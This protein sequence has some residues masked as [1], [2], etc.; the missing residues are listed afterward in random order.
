MT[1]HNNST[2]SLLPEPERGALVWTTS[3]SGPAR[4]IID[5]WERLAYSRPVLKKVNSWSFMPHPVEH[6]DELLTLAGFG[7]PID[8]S[9]GDRML[10]ELVRHAEHDEL[11][12]RIVLHRV[13]PSILSMVRRRGRVVPGGPTA[14]MNEAIGAAWMV[15]R[16]FPH[17]R[18]HHKIAANLVRDIEYHAFVREYRLKRVTESQIGNEMMVNV[19]HDPQIDPLAERLDDVLCEALENGVSTEHIV[20]LERLAHGETTDQLAREVGLS[21][22]TLRNRRRDAINAVRLSMQWDAAQPQTIGDH[23][24]R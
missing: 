4:L 7:R 6:L 10:W 24:H 20:L 2:Q 3:A 19:P 1:Q 17:H 8:D 13:M 21:T 23:K 15:I 18:R 9:E 12:A 14:A 16:Q 22:R 11:A 5:E